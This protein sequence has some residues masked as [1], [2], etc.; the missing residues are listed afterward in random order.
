MDDIG[1][2][3][4]HGLRVGFMHLYSP[5]TNRPAGFPKELFE[6]QRQGRITQVSHDDLAEMS[7]T[8]SGL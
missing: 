4:E 7:E 2:L 5:Q 6:L 8:S 3:Q 1:V